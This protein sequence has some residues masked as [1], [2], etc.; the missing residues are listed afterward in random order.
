MIPTDIFSFAFK[1]LR[2]YRLRT[3][4]TLLAMAIGVAA[5][6]VL[7]ALG[8]GARGYVVGEFRSLGTNLLIVL[9][10]RSETVGGPPPLMAETPRDL[11][12]DDALALTRSPAVERVTP[13][14]LG[15]APVSFKQLEREATVI[16]STAEFFRVRSLTL[17]KGRMLPPGD[18]RRASPVCVLGAELRDELFGSEPCLGQWVRIGDRRF[19]VLGVLAAKGVS[20][21]LDVD[22]TI[23]VPVASAQALFDTPSLF[24]VLV[25]ARSREAIEPAKKDILRLIRERHDGEEDI[26]VITQ[27]AVLAT[28][29]KIFQALTFAVAGIAA[30]SLGVA[31]L[32][33]MNVMLV[34]V[35]QRTAE[36]GL[37]K[38]VG[39]APGQILVLFL[40]EAVCLSVAGA[41]V[42]LLVGQAGALAIAWAYPEIPFRVPHWAVGAALGVALGTGILFGALPARRAARLDPVNALSRR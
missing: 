1:A 19:R 24:R 14:S 10:G 23:V 35:S 8:E 28:F 15:Q 34:A 37:L 18:P 7:T 32:L 17:G 36:I 9:P 21:G 25:A 5:V 39:A 27:D 6:V 2:G 13:I 11:T 4:L 40:S 29:D 22:E 41:V 33:I 3:A 26:T 31:G 38:A 20:I 12:I 42:G 30:I 16:G